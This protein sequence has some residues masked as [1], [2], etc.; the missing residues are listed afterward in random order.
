VSGE[1]VL[2]CTHP[3]GCTVIPATAVDVEHV[4]PHGAQSGESRVG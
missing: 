2:L 3:Q 4:T 1:M